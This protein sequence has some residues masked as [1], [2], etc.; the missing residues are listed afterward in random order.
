MPSGD[1]ERSIGV[2]IDQGKQEDPMSFA[3]LMVHVD[4]EHESEQ[5]VELA[6]GLADRFQTALIGVAGCA[7]WPAF[8]AGDVGLSKPTQYDFQKVMAR[9]EQ[10]GKKFRAQGRSLSQIEWRSA[11][12][13]PCELLLREARAADLL[14]IGRRRSEGDDDP[15]VMLLR[16]GRPVLLVPDT[17]AALPLRRV[18]VAWKDRR[19]C[20]RAV[21]DALPFLQQA[22]EVVLV[23]IGEHESQSQAKKNLAD[24]AAYLVRHRVIVAAEVWRQSRGRVAAELLHVVQEEKAD[25]IVAGGYG[26]SR[27]GEWIFGGV[28][29]ELLTASPVCCMLSH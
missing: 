1:V 9:F 20:R 28:T 10:R 24:V 5:R 16:A 29:R 25:L 18:V 26:H 12:E 8:M 7:L 2:V 27:L 17:I 15:G 11:L 6:I 4:I 21:R 23:E 19:E 22:K 3:A 14:I 13:S